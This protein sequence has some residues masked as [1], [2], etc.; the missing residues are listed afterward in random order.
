MDAYDEY[1]DMIFRHCYLRI[2]E[3]EQAKKVMA[4]TFKQLWLFIARGNTVDSVKIFLFREANTLLQDVQPA[5]A[6]PEVLRSDS[7][8]M[9]QQI[10]HEHRPL[11]L[12]HYVDGF[13]CNEICQILGGSVEDRTQHLEQL[14]HQF[15]PLTAHAS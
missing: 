6:L 7:L 1:A 12:L 15:T 10:A 13:S 8:K 4:E 14:Q 9:L 3:R 5:T 2:S 11:F